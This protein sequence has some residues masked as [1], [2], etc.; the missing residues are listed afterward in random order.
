MKN[1]NGHNSLKLSVTVYDNFD[2]DPD[3][4]KNRLRYF[5]LLKCDDFAASVDVCAQSVVYL[6]L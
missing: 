5:M 6:I 4:D 3:A 1:L 2:A